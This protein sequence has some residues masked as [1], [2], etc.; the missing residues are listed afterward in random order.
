MAW[1]GGYDGGGG[2]MCMGGERGFRV[3][4]GKVGTGLAV[5]SPRFHT[6]VQKRDKAKFS[7]ANTSGVL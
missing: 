1:S 6:A 7:I 3:L 2:S 4:V 5:L